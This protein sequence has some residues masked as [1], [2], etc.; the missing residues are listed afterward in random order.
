MDLDDLLARARDANPE[1]EL[2]G[3]CVSGM[4]AQ[5]STAVVLWNIL[6]ELC[7]WRLRSRVEELREFLAELKESPWGGKDACAVFLS[8]IR[9]SGIYGCCDAIEYPEIVSHFMTLHSATYYV[10]MTPDDLHEDL[11]D[12]MLVP[13]SGASPTRSRDLPLFWVTPREAATDLSS[14]DEVSTR[15]GLGWQEG[16]YVVEMRYPE[17][18]AAKQLKPTALSAGMNWRFRVFP[19]SGCYG[20][21]RNL[22]TMQSDLPEAVHL[23]I[24]PD[25]TFVLRGRGQVTMPRG[26]DP[27]AVLVHVREEA[28]EFL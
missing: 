28:E 9:Q 10:D 16:E 21:T 23:P 2:P 24:V 27:S 17:L 19:G 7:L 15:L 3:A 18:D 11:E 4:L 8:A 20:R 25:E 6:I 5:V 22:E 12:E 1:F 26:Q 14:A 13:C